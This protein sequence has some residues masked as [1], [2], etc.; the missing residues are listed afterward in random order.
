MSYEMAGCDK[1]KEIFSEKISKATAHN[2]V[3]II[4]SNLSSVTTRQ[5]LLRDASQQNNPSQITQYAMYLCELKEIDN[6]SAGDCAQAF[7]T[8]LPRM[9]SEAHIFCPT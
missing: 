8:Q 3:T 4:D 1:K 6:R 5:F 7:K 2:S 9:T